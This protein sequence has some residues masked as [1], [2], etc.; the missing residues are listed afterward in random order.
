MDMDM[1][2]DMK[3]YTV[4]KVERTKGNWPQAQGYRKWLNEIIFTK[5]INITF[6]EKELSLSLNT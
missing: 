2:S 4:R 5:Y 3:M 1:A 6:E